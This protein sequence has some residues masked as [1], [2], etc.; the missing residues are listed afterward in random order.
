MFP[1]VS[2]FANINDTKYAHLISESKVK[3]QK[4]IKETTLEKLNL[5]SDK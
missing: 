3:S 1:K 5:F 4:E 2:P